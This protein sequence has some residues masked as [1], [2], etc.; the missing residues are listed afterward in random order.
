M[1][2]RASLAR[3]QN[4]KILMVMK[5]TIFVLTAYLGKRDLLYK[6][7]IHS[8]GQKLKNVNFGRYGPD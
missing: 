3:M 1:R 2:F 5:K 8:P 6:E 7:C 4:L